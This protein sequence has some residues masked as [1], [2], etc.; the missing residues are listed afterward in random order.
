MIFST[1]L[2]HDLPDERNRTPPRFFTPPHD[3]FADESQK[4][5]LNAS[6][7]PNR[8]SQRGEA[9]GEIA[10]RNEPPYHIP[11]RNAERGDGDPKSEELHDSYGRF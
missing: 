9:S 3:I 5:K 1:R 6:E 10:P 7:E 8:D 11:N 2:L 4:Q